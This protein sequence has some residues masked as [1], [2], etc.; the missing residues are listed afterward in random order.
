MQKAWTVGTDQVMKYIEDFA[1]SPYYSLWHGSQL[2]FSWAGDQQKGRDVLEENIRTYEENGITDTFT[3]RLYSD[4]IK[5]DI[6]NKTPYSGSLNFRPTDSYRVTEQAPALGGVMFPNNRGLQAIYDKLDQLDARINT[7]EK[8]ETLDQGALGT[9]GKLLEMPGVPE[10]AAPLIGVISA[11]MAKT[12]GV[13]AAA[14]MAATPAMPAA[15]QGSI[16]AISED[17][18][19]KIDQA[20]DVLENASPTIGDDLLK[21]AQ[22]AE[23]D[24]GKFQMLLTMLR[25]QP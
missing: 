12:L 23:Q 18:A 5:G 6:T 14:A 13:D 8:G 10:A 25:S 21:L 17:Q 7:T 3:L 4:S 16:G 2:V 20:L 1:T 15:A 22:I 11:F 24:P 9:I 19:D